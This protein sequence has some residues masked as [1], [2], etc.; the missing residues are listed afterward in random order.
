MQQVRT[1]T[2]MLSTTQD[3]SKNTRR[4]PGPVFYL[5]PIQNAF[6]QGDPAQK[7]LPVPW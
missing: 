4:A 7:D 5:D 6:S 3:S 2:T 1:V